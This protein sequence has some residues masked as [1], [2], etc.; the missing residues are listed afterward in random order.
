MHAEACKARHMAL[1]QWW[2]GT[3]TVREAKRQEGQGRKPTPMM[4]RDGSASGSRPWWIF[5]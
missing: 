5:R 1:E 3:N 4:A 2:R